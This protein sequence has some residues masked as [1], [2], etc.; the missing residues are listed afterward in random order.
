V[1]VVEVLGIDQFQRLEGSLAV[2]PDAVR[3]AQEW[4]RT[5][6]RRL[7]R[8]D[9]KVIDCAPAAR[10][11]NI[12][13]NLDDWHGIAQTPLY[14]EDYATIHGI[15]HNTTFRMTFDKTTLYLAYETQNMG[16]FTNSGNQWDRLFKTGAAVDIQ[17]GTDPKADPARTRP[18]AGDL[19]LLIAP[20]AASKGRAKPAAV[21]YRPVAP[22]APEAESWEVVSPVWR[23]T[24]DSVKKLPDVRAA[25][26]GGASR[27]VVEIA[28]PLASIGLRIEPG[29]RLKLD[30]GV[31]ATDADGTVVLGRNYWANK[32]T[33]IL[34]DAPSE[35]ALHP[36]LW[37]YVR[38]RAQSRDAAGIADPD[39]L[40]RSKRGPDDDDLIDLR[41]EEE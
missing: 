14:S 8:R 11:I 20:M 13:A 2:T 28:V 36:D 15:P 1:S 33:S 3:Q 18:A 5:H 32:A 26:S 39:D 7:A 35:A 25:W 41:L 31:L 27:Y 34:S 4:Q 22:D 19:R 21:L 23:F 12:D 10:P 9:V 30:W 17:L 40:L 29:T 38:F 24:F 16:P 37:G 6:A